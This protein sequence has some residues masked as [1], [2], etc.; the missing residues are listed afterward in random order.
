MCGQMYLR[1]SNPTGGEEQV[2]G[3]G[4]QGKLMKKGWGLG[5]EAGQ[6]TSH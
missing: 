6:V 5:E 1:G 3:A 2:M 4:L